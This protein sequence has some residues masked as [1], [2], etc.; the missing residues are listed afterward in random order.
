MN[1][2]PLAVT[3]IGLMLLATT[4]VC[5]FLHNSKT[6]DTLMENNSQKQAV[7]EYKIDRERTQGLDKVTKNGEICYDY[8]TKEFVAF[9]ETYAYEVGRSKYPLC[10]LDM[11]HTYCE[12]YL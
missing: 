7:L 8:E 2:L 12:K 4:L 5:Y 10:A 11:F 3:I 1:T 6:G 9:D